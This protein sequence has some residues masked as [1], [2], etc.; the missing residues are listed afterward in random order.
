MYLNTK[1]LTKAIELQIQNEKILKYLIITQENV[2][3]FQIHFNEIFTSQK[4]YQIFTMYKK[5]ITCLR[6]NKFPNIIKL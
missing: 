6:G 2:N 1:Y 3:I 5:V 4:L